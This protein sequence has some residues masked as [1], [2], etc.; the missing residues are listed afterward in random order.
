MLFAAGFGTRMGSLTA[1]CPKPLINV[2]GKPL[3]DHALDLVRAYN[4][5]KIV[6]NLHY[7]PDQIE[8]H[9]SG[10]NI[11][12]SREEPEILE[13]G[14][15]LRAAQSLLGASPVFTMNTDAIWQG[16][17]PLTYLADR[18]HEEKM[19]AL[20][21]C[22]PKAQALGHQGEGDFIINSDNHVTRG[23]G[24][25]YSGLQI[26][27][28]NLLP[29]IEQRKFSLNLLWDIMLSEGRLCAAEY[30]GN[31]CDVGQPESIALA[32]NLLN[33]VDV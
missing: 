23:P 24:L 20:L 7:L 6:V 17:N 27:K 16:P 18:W 8:A 5:A 15:G 32:E 29:T 21:L 1:T 10:S 14:G 33:D 30:P 2:A 9:L 22:I 26:I 31:W 12:F 25:I 3:I 11:F 4:P 13:T 28:T 19:D